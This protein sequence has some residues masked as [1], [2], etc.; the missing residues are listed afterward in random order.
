MVD[1]CKCDRRDCGKK[2]TCFRYLADSY[3]YGQ[4]FLVVDRVDV[5][6]GCDDYWQCRTARELELMNKLN[7]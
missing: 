1:I 6:N 4:S 3:D 5:E 2:S 7:K